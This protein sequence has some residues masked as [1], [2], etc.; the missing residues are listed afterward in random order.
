MRKLKESAGGVFVI[1]LMDNV[2]KYK[3]NYLF[4]MIA[5]MIT[6]A[7][8]IAFFYYL[9]FNGQ[10]VNN[11]IVRNCNIDSA[12]KLTS[13][14]DIEMDISKPFDQLYLPVAFFNTD[15]VEIILN[16]GEQSISTNISIQ[17]DLVNYLDPND[18]D[19]ISHFWEH[20]NYY[21][22]EGISLK[23]DKLQNH[24][25]ISVSF[26]GEN[27]FVLIGASGGSVAYKITKDTWVN[28]FIFVLVAIT[29]IIG[30]FVIKYKINKKADVIE[31]YT[32]I[33]I[34]LGIIY[35]ILFPA[36]CTNDSH[37]HI[38][39]IYERVNSILGHSDWNI[40]DGNPNL[41]IY[42]VGDRYV[43]EQV[44]WNSER[45]YASPD[46]KMYD[47]A[48]Y[49]PLI[50][51]SND[52]TAV[53]GWHTDLSSV[54]GIEYLPYII[55]MLITRLLNI[56]LMIGL[57]F[58]KLAGFLCYLFMIRFAIKLMPYGKEALAVFALTPMI[59]QSMVAVSYDLFC[60][61]ASFIAFAYVFRVAGEKYKYTWKDIVI[62]LFLILVLVPA[63]GCVY[64]ACFAFMLFFMV[65]L[66]FIRE[67]PK[68]LIALGGVMVC[69]GG[70]VAVKFDDIKVHFEAASSECYSIS[71]LIESPAETI[72]YMIES[73][74]KDA[75]MFLQGM[76]G[77][78]L[79][80][81]EI[82]VPWF[83]V[84]MYIV[85]FLISCQC[86]EIYYP[87]KTEKVICLVASLLFLMGINY[88]FLV[89]TVKGS[90][91]IFGIQGRYF[92]PIFPLLISI[93]KSSKI[94]LKFNSYVLYDSLWIIS[95][96]HI[97]MT[98]SV[99]LRR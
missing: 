22:M 94:K 4:K 96:I 26:N 38:I 49:V 27:G 62:V 89:L 97:M 6:V 84:F 47:E 35:F 18:P 13:S 74:S 36:A 7:I 8:M 75:D 1:T 72:R 33:A 16:D 80:W 99:Y 67:N 53:S 42:N 25:K 77:G 10:I 58:V 3:Q 46:T 52:E 2:G 37:A 61:G 90:P 51:L 82:V 39:A 63:K 23:P 54:N 93:F 88:V 85:L 14:D 40:V 98:M 55:V 21:R 66:P 9:F 28:Y 92:V 19:Y 17:P 86:D 44:L 60:I 68:W 30:I 87:N 29:F 71:D 5:S 31:M 73:I 34:L 57:N 50:D 95:I 81:N 45:L 79:G 59:M 83:V 78:R 15:S 64:F 12:I 56:N 32:T 48:F 43:I 70:I 24:Y 91:T 69:A 11:Y 20:Q 65:I 76:F 41:T